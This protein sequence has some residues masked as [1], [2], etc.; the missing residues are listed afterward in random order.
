MTR[1]APAALLLAAAATLAADWP[2]FR[3]TAEQIGVAA[4]PLPDKLGPRWTHK[5]GTDASTAVVESTAAIVG[6]TAY[7]GAFDDYLYALDLATGTVKWKY[8]LGTDKP[9][10]IKAPVGVRDGAV[11]AGTVEGIFHCVDAA[12]GKGRWKQ[13]I[14]AGITSGANFHGGDVLF[15]ADDET[16]YCLSRADGTPRWKFQISGGPVNGTPAVTAGKTFAAGCDSLLHVLDVT[17]GKELTSVDLKGQVAGSGA[18]RGGTLYLGTMSGEV[19][20]VDLTKTEVTWGY[21]PTKGRPQFFASSAATEK[22]IVIGGRD[23]RVYAIDRATGKEAWTFATDGKVDSSP[24]VAGGRA[25]VGSSDG[26]LYVLDLATGGE[27][28]RI[29]LDGPVSASPAIADGCLVIGTEKGTI[30]CFGAAK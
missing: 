4:S 13:T 7:V 24:V 9:D 14:D 15:G 16:L 26:R 28:Q 12:T 29:T 25:Y 17:T 22:L 6:G 10:A 8:K 5:V 21:R 20:A 3:G 1:L 30:Y 11:Y 19:V 27:V 23:R 18:V 2:T